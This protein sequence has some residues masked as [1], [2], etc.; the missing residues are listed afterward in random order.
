MKGK[1]A[2]QWVIGPLTLEWSTPLDTKTDLSN[3]E[4]F[5]PSMQET[6]P[7]ASSTIYLKASKSKRQKQLHNMHKIQRRGRQ[8]KSLTNSVTSVIYSGLLNWQKGRR[9]YQNTS[10][11]IPWFKTVLPIGFYNSQGYVRHVNCS[12]TKPPHTLHMGSQNEIA[13]IGILQYT[14]CAINI[15]LSCNIREKKSVLPD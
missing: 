4:N 12:R 1:S 5:P 6:V 3:T 10:S 15:D 14:K 7:P 11:H 2:Y 13:G 9:N 8:S